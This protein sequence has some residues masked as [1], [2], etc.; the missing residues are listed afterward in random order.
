M[1]AEELALVQRFEHYCFD[2]AV[3]SYKIWYYKCSFDEI[4]DKHVRGF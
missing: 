2:R 3:P 1:T 4:W